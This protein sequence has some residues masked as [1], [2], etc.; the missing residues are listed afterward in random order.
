MYYY[1][2]GFLLPRRSWVIPRW[3]RQR[4]NSCHDRNALWQCRI[5]QRYKHYDNESPT[6]FCK[7]LTNLFFPF[8]DRGSPICSPIIDDFKL[9]VAKK[10]D[11]PCN[12]CLMNGPSLRRIDYI[13]IWFDSLN[14]WYT[15]CRKDWFIWHPLYNYTNTHK[16][17][18][19]DVKCAGQ[20]STAPRC[21]AL[22]MSTE[23][24][25]T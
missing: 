7:T 12:P 16:I 18:H 14:T 6:N 11:R 2:T 5:D 13:I 17:W 19:W 10:S 9:H 25:S 24:G 23:K 21:K 15:T 20:V 1:I 4:S 3:W 22:C 8:K